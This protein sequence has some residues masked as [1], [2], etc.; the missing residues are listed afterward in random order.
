M[1]AE[2]CYGVIGLWIGLCPF[3]PL[4]Y[5]YLDDTFLSCCVISSRMM[6]TPFRGDENLLNGLL[7][8]S[9]VNHMLWS[10]RFWT[11]MLPSSK[12][13]LTEDLLEE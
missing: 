6:M 3:V 10:G 7:S 12:R 8:E 13:L 11:D 2:M 9:S 5:A 1:I 4:E